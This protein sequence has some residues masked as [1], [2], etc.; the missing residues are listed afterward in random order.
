[1]THQL[2]AL[3][4]SALLCSGCFI[5]PDVTVLYETSVDGPA[6]GGIDGV[7]DTAAPDGP[8]PDQSIP[9]GPAPDQSIP[10]GP[11]ADLPLTDQAITDGPVADLP[12]PDQATPDGPVPDAAAPPLGSGN[13]RL[14][15]TETTLDLLQRTWSPTSSW[16]TPASLLA[17]TKAL[18]WV[19]NRVSPTTPGDE[20]ALIFGWDTGGT[21]LQGLSRSAANG[22]SADW[23]ATGISIADISKQGFDLAYEQSSGDLLVVYSNSTDTPRFRTR[24]GGTWSAEQSLPL[25]DGATNPN[26]DHN[27]GKVLWIELVPRPGSNDIALF[28]AD[29]NADLVMVLWDGSQWAT[30]S[31]TV[32][33]SNL[34]V[35]P[36]SSVV[37]QRCFD[38]AWEGKTGDLLAAWG[39]TNEDGYFSAWRSA[40]TGLWNNLPAFKGT[41]G[42]IEF[43]DLEGQAASDF[44]VGAFMDEGGGIERLVL[45]AWD[46]TS[47]I[48]ASELDSQTHDVNDQAFGDA[49]A[50]VAWV[51][52]STAVAVYADKS[53][54]VLDWAKWTPATG[55][56]IQ[57]DVT[58]FN[59]GQTESVQLARVPGKTQVLVVY[60]DSKSQL[61]WALFNGVGWT[62]GPTWLSTSV[63]S[64]DA[65]PFSLA[66]Q[67]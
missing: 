20:A 41:S 60:T 35:N 4:V 23:S 17:F 29:A 25:N 15:Y 32:L 46:G 38:G 6:D 54:N 12:L 22:W 62:I 28:Y 55:W 1:M 24:S 16:D 49:P 58:V 14:L 52:A 33:E 11:V 57:S 53:T 9:D 2:T 13:A 18:P 43:V 50:G 3:L 21:E 8:A 10:D 63:A 26:P 42:E 61:G 40:T 44:I 47:W 31:A 67:Q 27:T 45:A 39:R 65:V 66:F 34:K 36:N 5:D 7:V 48:N 56:V 30:G 37:N 19:L 59:K 64:L 51:D